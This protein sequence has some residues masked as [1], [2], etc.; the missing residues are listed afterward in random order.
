VPLKRSW[1]WSQSTTVSKVYIYEKLPTLRLEL[2]KLSVRPSVEITPVTH[3]LE[4]PYAISR[5]IN[6]TR[7][8]IV[9]IH[10][11]PGRAVPA[12]F[13]P[14]GVDPGNFCGL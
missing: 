13:S 3:L 11:W 12:I 4:F 5:P 2:L 14:P 7:E 6:F 9:S 8:R 1:Y 10:L